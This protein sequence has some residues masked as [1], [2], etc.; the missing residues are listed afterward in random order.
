M[1]RAL[2]TRLMKRNT[3]HPICTNLRKLTWVMERLPFPLHIREAQR[4]YS[5]VD[6]CGQP[7]GGVASP[8]RSTSGGLS[9]AVNLGVGWSHLCGQ[10]R[11]ALSF[12]VNLGMGW[13]HPRD[14]A[15]HT[16]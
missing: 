13:P 11:G 16:S 8:L 12:A 5:R 9:L 15:S 4:V 10:P 1:I 3:L 14:Q 7:W 6:P 2:V